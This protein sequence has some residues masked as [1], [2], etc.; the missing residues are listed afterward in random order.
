MLSGEFPLANPEDMAIP[1]CVAN[2]D[3][4]IA[5]LRHYHEKWVGSQPS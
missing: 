5:V 3:E 4:A 1:E 2:A